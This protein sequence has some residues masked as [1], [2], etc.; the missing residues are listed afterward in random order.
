MYGL[1][2]VKKFCKKMP[3]VRVSDSR[4]LLGCPG[5]NDFAAPVTTFRAKVYDPVG[6]FDDIQVMLDNHHGVAMIAQAVQYME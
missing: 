3:G 1:V 4:Q 2:S 5:C 6:G